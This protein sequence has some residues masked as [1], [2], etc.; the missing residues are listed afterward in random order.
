MVKV[1]GG[2]RCRRADAA[3]LWA[4]CRGSSAVYDAPFRLYTGLLPPDAVL[5]VFA[6]QL[7]WIVVLVLFGRFLLSRG[8]RRLA[9][10][11]HEGVNSPSANSCQPTSR[12]IT[13][14]W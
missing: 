11:I 6:R 1:L 9:R 3:R 2:T 4:A 12:P 7:V 5:G 14:C 8:C 10:I 13:A